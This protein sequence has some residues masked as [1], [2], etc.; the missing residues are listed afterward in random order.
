MPFFITSDHAKIHY[1]LDGNGQPLVLL[2]GY[3]S[4]AYAFRR[5]IPELSKHYTVIAVDLRGHG[6][7][8]NVTY[9]YH[10]ERL[11]KDVE[12]LLEALDLKDAVLL[13]WS[14][15]CSVIWGYW[16]LFRDKRLA[17]LI[18]FD[19]APC[20]LITPENPNG[21]TDFNGLME[22]AS[23]IRYNFDEVVDTLYDGCLYTQEAKDLYLESL[24]EE[25][26]KLPPEGGAALLLHHCYADWSD[27]IPTINIPTLCLGS[28]KLGMVKEASNRWNHEHI[29]GSE[30]KF[31]SGAHGSF[32][33]YP[34][35][36]N[37]IVI[38]FIG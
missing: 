21:F 12:E 20:N 8:E 24:V 33:E 6:E 27:V 15:G 35:E 31:L 4:T 10:M 32:L 29:K 37:K 17:K 34:E 1:T 36:F 28:T 13:G 11:S 25:G 3:G 18:L 7:S 9:G 14:M 23:N 38:D 26:R 30:L 22:M 19:E 16:D 2:H 5:N